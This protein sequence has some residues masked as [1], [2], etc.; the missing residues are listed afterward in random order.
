[1]DINVMQIDSL[2]EI[3]GHK[4]N[5]PALLEAALTHSSYANE[6]KNKNVG[7]VYNERLEFLGDSVLS[8]IVSEHIF[9]EY[10]K[11]PEGELTKIRANVVCE[12][13][14]AKLARS[15]ELGKYLRLG[16]G[17]SNGGGRERASILADA[18]EAVLAAI[19]LDSGNDKEEVSK[20]LMP[21]IGP[22][23]KNY[24]SAGLMTDYKT[25][26]QQIIQQA[27]GERL[28]YV[29]IGESGP[30]HEKVFEVEARLNSN[31]IGHGSGRSK[32]AAE[33]N[34]AKMALGYFKK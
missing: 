33:Q 16:H 29:L 31:I 14:L 5:T 11:L 20:F 18:F 30:D 1:M 6:M 8:I 27:E 4:F 32:R 26:L 28:E 7:I 2:E 21:L 17:E 12:K 10:K 24:V 23:I 9:D 3:I 22:E 25:E 19:Y 13:T 15:I 34:A